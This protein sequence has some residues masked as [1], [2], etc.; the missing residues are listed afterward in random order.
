MRGDINS[1]IRDVKKDLER[2]RMRLIER[3][4]E[5]KLK[6]K[7]VN[8]GSVA[9][10]RFS[11]G[12]SMS[13]RSEGHFEPMGGPGKISTSKKHLKMVKI[14]VDLF[15]ITRLQHIRMRNNSYKFN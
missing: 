4:G 9:S 3:N 15:Y 11:V 7:I 6:Q 14:K 12:W 5:S 13:R 10:K 1:Q 8:T 2:E